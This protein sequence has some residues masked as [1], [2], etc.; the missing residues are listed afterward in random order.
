[1]K[2]LCVINGDVNGKIVFKQDTPHS[3]LQIEGYLMGLTRGLHGFHVHEYGD[4]SNGCVS[5]G[6]HFNPTGSDHGGPSA[7]VRHVGDLGNVE[8]KVSNSLT[9][10]NLT[11][12]VMSLFGENSVIGRSLVVHSDRDDLGLGDSPLSK[13]TGNSGGRLGCGI[14]GIVSN[15]I[16]TYTLSS[17]DNSLNLLF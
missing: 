15:D 7:A 4:V 17:V 14:I 8:V 11:D 1:M 6:E 9:E 5:A 12:S 13:I 10:I 2:A 3:V 16:K